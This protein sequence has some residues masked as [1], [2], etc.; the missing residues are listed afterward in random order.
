MK[1]LLLGFLLLLIAIGLG[2]SIQQDPGYLLIYYH[3]WS[4]STSLWAAII[5]LVIILGILYYIVKLTQHF[6]SIRSHLGHWSHSR[7]HKKALSDFDKGLCQILQSD[8]KNA[9][10]TFNKSFDHS[11]SPL[12]NTYFLILAANQLD[13]KTQI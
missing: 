1:K 13:D 4:L 2:Y 9:A 3:H 7:K 10:S 6:L 11:P 5:S 8:W 12:I